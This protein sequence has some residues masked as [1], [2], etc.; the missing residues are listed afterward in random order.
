MKI[1]VRDRVTLSAIL[2]VLLAFAGAA[3]AQVPPVVSGAGP[4]AAAIDCVKNADPRFRPARADLPGLIAACEARLRSEPGSP[5][6]QTALARAYF[7]NQEFDRA[8]QLAEKAAAQQQPFAIS[9]LGALYADGVG[10][11]KDFARARGYFERAAALGF[12]PA[13]Y[14]LGIAYETG[15]DID[16]EPDKAKQYYER[17]AAAGSAAA[18]ARLGQWYA[19]GINVE[20]DLARARA[21]FEASLALDPNST[22]PYFGLGFVFNVVGDYPTAK[23]YFEK[24]IE[25]DPEH[26]PALR[27]LGHLYEHGTGVPADY[28]KAREY[29][30]Q[31]A[32]LQDTAALTDLANLYRSGSG[33]AQD[34][35]KARVFLDLAVELGN[36]KAMEEL[37]ELYRN[38]EGGPKSDQIAEFWLERAAARK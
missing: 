37:A 10:V 25:L 32:A 38:G 35:V 17:A 8:R 7:T 31:A 22:A 26:A 11:A 4:G 30:E 15:R 23:K 5:A 12:A 28:A 13:L 21:L 19:R 6:V 29:Y 14:D 1:S 27:C 3:G 2:P 33:V 24:T 34:F 18:M 9:L 16:R 20:Q 36:T